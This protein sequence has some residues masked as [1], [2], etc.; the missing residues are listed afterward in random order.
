MD[1]II[2]IDENNENDFDFSNI[3][4]ASPNSLQ[5]GSYFTKIL[6]NQ[7]PL[8]IQIPQCSTKQGII[9][10]EKKIYCD[11]M[12]KND[13]N[14]FIQWLELFE[15]RCH[16]LIYEKRHLW[17]NN[18]F[19]LSDIENFFTS[20]T[21]VYKSG[22]FFLVRVHIP[23]TKIIKKH[24]SCIIYDE[25]ENPLTY[26]DLIHDKN[27]IP[28]THIEGIK[29]SSKS[30]QIDIV[31]NQIMVLNDVPDIKQ[32]CIIKNVKKAQPEITKGNTLEYTIHKKEEEVAT[33]QEEVVVSQEEVAAPQEEVVVSQEEVAAPQEEVVTSI[34]DI[35]QEDIPNANIVTKEEVSITS[36]DYLE[37]KENEN[38]KEKDDSLEIVNT[39]LKYELEEVNLVPTN[40][41]ETITL[42]KPNEVYYE[43]YKAAREKAKMAKKAAIETYLE[44]KNIK[45]QYMLEDI[46]DSEESDEEI[47]DI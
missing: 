22:Q 42:K 45:N 11:L 19:E 27:I 31:L 10:T 46:E 17:F 39:G 40:N 21:R 2:S 3:T 34:E 20:P 36:D 13:N 25:N 1:N 12:F 41:L 38:I 9:K 24:K 15:E 33:P 35:L 29:F 28:L 30:F 6:N 4:L 14:G 8:Y 23:N 43:I 26:D 44:A 18:D 5:G 47:E 32:P 16:Q 37:K 7:K